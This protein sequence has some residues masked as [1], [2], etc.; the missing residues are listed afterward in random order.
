MVKNPPAV[1]ETWVRS[2]GWNDS[3]ENGMLPTLVFLSG[4]SPWTEEHGRLQSLGSQR[5]LDMTEGLSTAQT[6]STIKEKKIFFTAVHW[7][8]IVMFSCY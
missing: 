4:E 3:L 8:R 2:L 5:E 1:W 6:F 7:Y